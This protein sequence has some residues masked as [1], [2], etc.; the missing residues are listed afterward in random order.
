MN[1][2]KSTQILA[3]DPSNLSKNFYTEKTDP[4]HFYSLVDKTAEL[5]ALW[6]TYG[7]MHGVLNTDN[8]SM[9]GLTIDY[10]PYAFMDYFEKNE[11]KDNPTLEIFYY[12]A[13]LEKT[14]DEK[15]F[16]KQLSQEDEG[17]YHHGQYK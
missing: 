9:A 10:G 17:K 1:I 7:F 3:E 2:Q 16:H 4:T 15:Y 14:R 11:I 13:I 6:Q 8:F 5:F 12:I